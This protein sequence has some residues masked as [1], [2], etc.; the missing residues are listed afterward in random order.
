MAWCLLNNFA[1]LYLS[2]NTVEDQLSSLLE[3]IS[4][5]VGR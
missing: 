1:K 4:G 5:E 2:P 3:K